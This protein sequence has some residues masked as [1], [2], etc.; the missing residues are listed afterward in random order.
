MKNNI[1]KIQS[2]DLNIDIEPS[3]LLMPQNGIFTEKSRSICVNFGHFLLISEPKPQ[4]S[5]KASQLAIKEE[6][7]S[8]DIEDE[9]ESFHS[10]TDEEDDEYMKP[11]ALNKNSNNSKSVES[12][13]TDKKKESA[14]E[15]E[16]SDQVIEAS[17]MKF[18][19][20]LKQIQILIIDDINDLKKIN[21]L[22]ILEESS[23]T[24]SKK[25]NPEVIEKY[26]ILTPLDLFL[27]VHQC[28]YGDDIRLP[29]LKI[30]GNLP[31]IDFDLS[32]TKLENIIKLFLSIPFPRSDVSY[33]SNNMS[34]SSEYFE[35]ILDNN[36][37]PSNET[38]DLNKESSKIMDTLKDFKKK[39]IGETKSSSELKSINKYL[40][41]DSLQQAINLEF[42]FEINEINFRLKEEKAKNFDW[43]LFKISSFGTLVQ[44]KT[45]DTH[46]NI[47]LN[48]ISCEYGLINDVNGSKL[49][50]ISSVNRG[51]T[52]SPTRSLTNKSGNNLIDIKLVQ[53][54]KDSPTLKLLH[55]SVLM[56][57]SIQ[58]CSID[59]VVNLIAIKNMLSFVDSFQKSINL[60]DYQQYQ[61]DIDS[62][63]QSKS[64]I[65]KKS[66]K[67]G[68]SNVP[69]LNDDQIKKLLA[70][71]TPFKFAQDAKADTQKSTEASSVIE[72]KLSAKMD[73][74]SAR[75]CTSKQNYFKINVNNFEMNAVNKQNEQNIEFI[76]NSISVQDME[77]NV[78]YDKIVS[79]KEN[80]E[81]LIN[82]QLTILNPPKTPYS[83]SLLAAQYQHE[84][85]YFKNYLNEEHFDLIIKAN[86]SKL[87]LMFLYK[88]LNT[89]LVN[90]NF[91]LLN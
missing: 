37:N 53:T 1:N 77:A 57:V 26:Y 70:K 6:T 78:K 27:N 84:K 40:T 55:D 25:L 12:F 49:Y 7:K 59:F 61:A 30:F 31:I 51:T 22:L 76:L 72:L 24:K 79:L 19:M 64:Q 20:H 43:I 83:S 39:L 75:L 42:S 54:D 81:N 33:R 58:L 67:T 28:A 13:R 17:Y 60:A 29:A 35:D 62:L 88:H 18:Q 2:I 50:L 47:Y 4:S 44:T 82:V 41:A 89:V 15:L 38:A 66:A 71:Y 56:N 80:T 74:V 9:E 8:N 65:G 23:S 87:K 14:V 5:P 11:R 52:N 91:Y 69:L 85:Y 3:Y 86:I 21:D 48:Q 63:N 34:I 90:M 10:A 73:G 45:W 36:N 46:V 32:N 16:T 68:L